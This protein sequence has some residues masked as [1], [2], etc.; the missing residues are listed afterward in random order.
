[1]FVDSLLGA[2]SL[3][4]FAG[5]DAGPN[6]EWLSDQTFNYRDQKQG[7]NMD[8]MTYAV[9]TMANK[10]PR[11]L[12]N[13]STLQSLANKT[14]STFF[15]HYVSSNVSLDIGGWAYQ[16]INASLPETLGPALGNHS[17]DAVPSIS[18]TDPTAVA[19]V[20]TR[21]ELLEMNAV[22]LWL[23]IAVL[24]WLSATA[25]VLS[26]LQKRR[27]YL[28]SS[29]LIRKFAC[30]GDMLIVL[31][32]SERLLR[33]VREQGPD[34]DCLKG[35]GSNLLTRLGWFEGPDGKSRWGLE[36]VDPGQEFDQDG[37]KSKG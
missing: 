31:A 29:S 34:G 25:L 2:A 24:I 15:Q 9:Y 20:S 30:L 1:M 8:F 32:G 22:A 17:Q 7:L 11:A 23:S 4:E 13:M 36:L 3:G 10:D 6:V 5:A 12:L 28:S 18:H 33:L 37:D 35:N 14:F 27:Y 26:V 16:E 19:H 21:I